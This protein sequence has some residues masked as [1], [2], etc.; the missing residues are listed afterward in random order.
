MATSHQLLD[1]LNAAQRAAVT[2]ID[3]PLLV[4][5]GPGSG[6]TRVITHRIA[7]MVDQ[8]IPPGRIVG[9]TFTN[10]AAQEMRQRV[11]RLV[12][13]SDVWLGTFHG[14][15]VR[16]LRRY[17]RL[18]GLAE[19]FT[20]YDAD[21]SL[22]LLKQVVA[23]CDVQ[24]THHTP[25]QLA[26]RISFYKNRLVTPEVIQSQELAASEHLA[27]EIYPQ[28]Q[29]MLLRHGA[30]DFDDILMHVALLLRGHPEV[31]AELDAR[32][33]YLMVDEYQDTNLAQYVIL[34]HLKIDHPHLAVTGDPDQS[35]YGWRGANIK[36]IAYLERDYPDLR[37]VRLEENYR[38]TAPIL[39]VADFLISHNEMRKPKQLIPARGG[40][41]AVRLAIYATGRQEAE[42]VVQ[43]IEMAVEQEGRELRDF[44][45]LYRTN[46]QSRLFEQ[47]LV[48]RQIPYQLI[49]GFRF[50]Q[51]KEIKDL[52]AY[53]LLLYNP[54]DDVALQRAINVPPR[55]IGK[56]TLEKLRDW[57][58]RGGVSMLESCRR[59]AGGTLRG[60]A[61]KAVQ[62]FVDLFDGLVPLVHGPAAELLE[63]VID[64][65]GYREFLAGK[66]GEDGDEA[67]EN[68]DELLQEARELDD[69]AHEEQPALERLLEGFALQ[70]DV[71]SM[72]S[73][74][75]CVTLMTLHAAKGLEFPV[76]FIV[77]V[78]EN[79]LPHARAKD[80]PLGIEEER[81]L[82]FVGLTRARDALQVSYARQRGFSGQGGG[83]VPS[84][85]L[86]E[87]PRGDMQIRD[88]SEPVETWSSAEFD[89]TLDGGGETWDDLCQDDGASIDLAAADGGDWE[90][91]QLPPEEIAARL[92]RSDESTTRRQGPA[93]MRNRSPLGPAKPR[94]GCIVRHA[95]YGSGR[96]V[97]LSG[98]GTRQTVTVDFGDGIQRTFRVDH[99]PLTV[100]NNS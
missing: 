16:L 8:G 6:K 39:A 41:A 66:S 1:G 89:E 46:A 83:G 57:A 30:V 58:A 70:S 37:T 84:S 26:Q 52:M 79:I 81:R 20:I 95:K 45:I 74:G 21:D 96:V 32:W 43:Q 27:A 63:A 35:I 18:V 61:G 93:T 29:R 78:E 40:G 7:Y 53:L 28:Y 17:A 3:G 60:R 56:Q 15:C 90:L 92:R 47:A 86:M 12:G 5:A 11:Q 31:R 14:F 87:L 80:D 48:R 25:A 98:S 34:R 36:N 2:H 19:N 73:G 24:L 97:R 94:P 69:S 72:Q 49:G 91:C 10:K 42:D 54:Q 4:L 77:A 100:E 82:L 33:P 38:S 64:R 99:A 68:L 9:L 65:I 62:G 71:D 51:R 67:I 59:L 23:A 85:F 22:A 88:L 75:D 13:R 44:G 50:Y 55:G 76:V